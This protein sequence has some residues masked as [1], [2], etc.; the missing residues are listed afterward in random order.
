MH[1]AILIYIQTTQQL[2]RNVFAMQQIHNP[3]VHQQFPNFP[4]KAK[5]EEK[6]N[7]EKKEA[8]F[9]SLKHHA[10]SLSL[11]KHTSEHALDPICSF[12]HNS[13]SI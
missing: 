12:K 1:I 8:L 9:L 6:K 3:S 11:A 10:P 13:H 7:T 2:M 5:E 4:V